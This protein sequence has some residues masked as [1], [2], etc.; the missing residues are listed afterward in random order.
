ME[1]IVIPESVEEIKL[2]AFKGCSSLK[3]M[4][5]EGNVKVI[6]KNAFEGCD[7]LP[8]EIKMMATDE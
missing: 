4:I 6:D 1:R 5:F 7:N 2:S 8:E 3:E